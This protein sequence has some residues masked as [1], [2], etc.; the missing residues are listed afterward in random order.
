M[1]PWKAKTR[2][3]PTLHG[4]MGGCGD[5]R[6]AARNRSRSRSR[7][8]SNTRGAKAASQF[9]DAPWNRPK[10]KLVLPPLHR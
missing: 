2:G 3:G 7:S 6:G 8:R 1:Q 10:P 5:G 9:P 4:A